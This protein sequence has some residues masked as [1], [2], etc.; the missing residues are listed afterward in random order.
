MSD[1]CD[2]KHGKRIP[3]MR[4][5]A[6]PFAALTVL[7]F[8]LLAVFI[9]SFPFDSGRWKAVS[10]PFPVPCGIQVFALPQQPFYGSCC[11]L[12]LS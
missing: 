8:L 1:N 5:A 11:L 4:V 6:V 10:L 9:C 12:L 7:I 2:S 3:F